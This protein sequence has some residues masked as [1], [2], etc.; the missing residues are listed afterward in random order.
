[1]WY[2]SSLFWG[3]KVE[4]TKHIIKYATSTDGINWDRHD[5]TCIEPKY[6]GEFAIVKPFVIKEDN[7]Y[8]MWYSYRVYDNYKMGYAESYDG[9]DWER[10]D[11]QVGLEVS[12][13]GWDSE[14]VCYPFIFEH[15]GKRYMLY[16]GNSYGKTGF[17]LAILEKK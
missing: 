8:K 9:L 17:G 11:E 13:T 7:I 15:K 1:M 16:N 4:E 14:M 12:P 2:G 3:N 6:E 5:V 10:K